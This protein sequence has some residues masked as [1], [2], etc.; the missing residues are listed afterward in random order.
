MKKSLLS[1]CLLA[2]AANAQATPQV[3]QPNLINPGIDGAQRQGFHRGDLT[4]DGRLLVAFRQVFDCNYG[5]YR[6]ALTVV[7]V[8]PDGFDED[9]NGYLSGFDNGGEYVF[10]ESVPPVG[11][12]CGE[13]DLTFVQ[14]A[15]ELVPCSPL[16]GDDPA[17]C[18]DISYELPNQPGIVTTSVK[19]NSLY[20]TAQ[21]AGGWIAVTQKESL[22]GSPFR[23]NENGTYNAAGDFLTYEL[24]VVRVHNRNDLGN[25]T[26]N[27]G[28]G[29]ILQ[30]P[31]VVDSGVNFDHGHQLVCQDLRVTL[32]AVTHEI[33][34]T[35][36]SP[37]QEIISDDAP[38]H[39]IGLPSGVTPGIEFTMTAD[40][41]LIVYHGNSN[42][43]NFNIGN[44]EVTY[45]YNNVG[46]SATGW[47]Q[48][49]SITEAP[50]LSELAGSDV[51]AVGQF[52]ER[53]RVFQEPI[54]LPR[55]PG[56][57]VPFTFSA[58]QPL[59]G[60]YPWI[61]RD[62]D[63]ILA[64]AVRSFHAF[65]EG[66]PSAPT[67]SAGYI[68][69]A[70]TGGYLKHVDDV[71]INPTRKA[72]EWYWPRYGNFNI[73]GLSPSWSTIGFSTGMK[74]GIWEP[75][76]RVWEP[77]PGEGAPIPAQDADQRIPVLPFIVSTNDTYGEV[78]F[79][80]RDGD[81]LLY[82]ACNEAIQIDS[83]PQA[84]NPQD[85]AANWMTYRTDATPDTAGGADPAI[86]LLSPGAAF[87]QEVLSNSGPYPTE[88]DA[89][90]ELRRLTGNALANQDEN[91]AKQPFHESI[92]FK[93]Q[94]ITFSAEGAVYPESS[95]G[96]AAGTTEFTAQAFAKLARPPGSPPSQTSDPLGGG[97]PVVP[98]LRLISHT[99]SFGSTDLDILTVDI[100]ADGSIEANV[101]FPI[102]QGSPYRTVRSDPGVFSSSAAWA[103]R[104]AGWHHIA[105]TLRIT[106]VLPGSHIVTLKLYVDGESASPSMTFEGPSPLLPGLPSTEEGT[107][108]F[109]PGSPEQSAPVTVDDIVLVM[110]EIAISTVART[111]AELRRD[112]YVG[113]APAEFGEWDAMGA[114]GNALPNGLEPTDADWPVD[115]ANGD[116]TGLLTTW[117]RDRETLGETLFAD[118]IL[119][120]EGEVITCTS[121]H[122]PSARF[123]DPGEAFSD[124][125]LS[126]TVFNTPSLENVAFGATRTFEGHS[127]SL[128]QQV[129]RPLLNPNE[130]GNPDMASVVARINNN[131][132][133]DYVTAFNEAFG[134]A[135][136]ATEERLRAALSIYMR[137][138]VSADSLFD[139]PP[140]GMSDDARLGQGL[141]FGKARC[142]SCHRDSSFTDETFHNI[143]TVKSPLVIE[144]LGGV[145]GRSAEDFALK[146]PSLRGVADTAP[147][148]HDG[149]EATLM[150]VIEH[151]NDPFAQGIDP[152]VL[153]TLDPQLRPLGLSTSEMNQLVAFLMTLSG[154]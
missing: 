107:W 102:G 92:G 1:L 33:Q 85:P 67:R 21:G 75:L 137:T 129:E 114:G 34:A 23:S 51:S 29:E 46:F 32:D 42:S 113:P 139:G 31:N 40:G 150:D 123:A 90:E 130:M 87:P 98:H 64:R 43:K 94:G 59:R 154:Q 110:D 74:P 19:P 104:R 78:R 119:S 116:P 73:V 63:F 118:P 58:S 106:E 100:E 17:N 65:E 36:I 149:S 54:R 18:V 108:V 126:G 49:R 121:C 96:F 131:A 24:W 112:A 71:G 15:L 25:L 103:D 45:I 61:S 142:F 138:L 124:G 122:H 55:L 152:E 115:P 41:R 111:P 153:E 37:Y 53:Y 82:L 117:T 83:H 56:E 127:P 27:P 120:R 68:A 4:P 99:S 60:P 28:G 2:P 84:D 140:T 81:Y 11:D 5:R 8:D 77:A 144:G 76:S 105:F 48:P 134:G 136:G 38:N 20:P 14:W 93:G 141:F 133:F 52:E 148:F 88:R 125:L 132:D 97:S 143:G 91:G 135:G 3:F 146:T 57:A 10:G 128:E 151:Y 7:P 69:G 79:E 16:I 26:F 72:G 89:A 47:T 6:P 147:Y 39:P 30:T 12:P 22:Y 109:G 66:V 9:A 145:T 101:L 35:E 86:V 80:E 50:P 62:G 95:M 70:I 13:T 44:G